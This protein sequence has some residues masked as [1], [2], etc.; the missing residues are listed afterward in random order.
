M[1]FIADAYGADRELVLA[2]QAGS[3]SGF[4]RFYERYFAPVYRYVLASVGRH[5]DAEDITADV[6]TK[7]FR[8]IGRF[9]DESKP[10]TAWLFR[11]ARNEIV[12]YHRRRGRRLS[13][14]PVDLQRNDAAGRYDPLENKAVIM[15]LN[16]ALRTLPAAQREALLL[17]LVSGLSTR[18][19]AEAMRMPE[20]TVRSHLHHGI[21]A[22]RAAMEAP[23]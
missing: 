12:D 8:S 16:R 6:F 7:A 13:P 20:G 5:H 11:I 15:D 14:V 3:E 2:C 17:R 21:R 1:A 22:L 18:Q 10:V 4:F 19:A 23:A 9:R